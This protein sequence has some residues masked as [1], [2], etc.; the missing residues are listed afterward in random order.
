MV[1]GRLYLR[2]T[3]HTAEWAQE[4]ADQ[5]TIRDS[6]L[7]TPKIGIHADIYCGI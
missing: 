4:L 2:I 1:E 7:W 6:E 5:A 3:C